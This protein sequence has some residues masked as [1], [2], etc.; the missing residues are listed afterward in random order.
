MTWILTGLLC[1]ALGVG[2]YSI[3]RTTEQYAAVPV[4]TPENTAVQLA[5]Q[6][7]VLFP[8]SLTYV[9]QIAFTRGTGLAGV[10]F[11][12]VERQTGIDALTLMAI[13]AHESAW[14]SN[15]WS[16][17][18]NNVMS[19]GVSDSD[20]DRSYYVTK[21]LCVLATAKGLKRLYLSEDATYYGGDLTLFGI[22]KYY[23]GD[24]NWAMAVLSIVKE[25]EGKMTEGQRVKR[26]CVKTG[27]FTPDVVWDYEHTVIGW[28]LYKTN[29]A[30]VVAG[31]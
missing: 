13:A 1:I 16:K 11:I 10:D 3:G 20:P 17:R 30:T 2:G 23:A 5:S 15:N 9:Q 19:W 31:R 27:L 21:T 8:S 7:T 4:E 25:L 14:G 12:Y 26:W 6:V 22:N 24:K 29:K 18:Y 28:A